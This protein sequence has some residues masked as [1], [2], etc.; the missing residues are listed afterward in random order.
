ME[1]NEFARQS[2]EA[3]E[4]MREMNSRSINSKGQ[5]MPPV[6]SFVRLQG[7][8]QNTTSQRPQQNTPAPKI[9]EAEIKKNYSK[10][11]GILSGL[12]IPFLDALSKDTDV[13]L[14]IG[15]LLILISEKADKK[16]LFALVY[17]LM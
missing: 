15:L 16:L 8:R 9:S 17:I 11:T 12:N 7:N 3:V 2:K 4:K 5:S 13:S 10:N 6:P 1:D 14:I